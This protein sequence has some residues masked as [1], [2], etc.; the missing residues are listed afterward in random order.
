MKQRGFVPILTILVL[1]ILVVVGY[2][3]YKNYFTKSSIIWKTYTNARYGYSFQYPQDADVSWPYEPDGYIFI[4]PKVSDGNNL[5]ITMWIGHY[6]NPN[7]LGAKD[8][9]TKQVGDAK[10]K[11]KINNHPVP[12]SPAGGT[13]EVVVNGIDTFQTLGN[14]AGDGTIT[15]AQGTN[16]LK[17]ISDIPLGIMFNFATNIYKNVNFYNFC[18]KNPKLRKEFIKK[19]QSARGITDGV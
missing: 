9:Y 18:D 13:K 5:D 10:A 7:S 2:F 6:P 19:L 14:F 4:N 12:I 15:D 16:L 11:A 8:F 3:G 1:A 17:F